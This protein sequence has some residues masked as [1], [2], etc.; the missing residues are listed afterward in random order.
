[1]SK[2]KA[3]RKTKASKALVRGQEFFEVLRTVDWGTI[4]DFLG[5][6]D[7][8][9]DLSLLSDPD[10]VSIWQYAR[11][12]LDFKTLYQMLCDLKAEDEWLDENPEE[13]DGSH[14]DGYLFN[15]A[16]RSFENLCISEANLK[17]AKT[18]TKFRAKNISV[19]ALDRMFITLSLRLHILKLKDGS[20]LEEIESLQKRQEEIMIE[21]LM[22]ANG[23]K[24]GGY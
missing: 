16:V 24:K 5:K 9:V 22:R 11:D 1:M 3:V 20:D 23:F 21:R 17:M 18:I 12:K 6:K 19:K 8:R 7:G 10:I 2:V 13:D 15:W 4:T 14:D